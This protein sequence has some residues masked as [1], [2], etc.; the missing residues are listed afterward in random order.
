MSHPLAKKPPSPS[1]PQTFNGEI[2][3]AVGRYARSAVLFAFEDIGGPAALSFWAERNKDDF[4]TKL[5][6]KIIARESEVT[7]HKTVD[8]LMD[9]ID[10]EFEVEGEFDESEE[11][12]KMV[13][14][15]P[16]EVPLRN[17]NDPWLEQ[18]DPWNC[19]G[20]DFEDDE[21]LALA[22]ADMVDFEE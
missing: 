5:F 13:P 9:V 19:S 11:V 15:N 22:G 14:V 16:D 4:Y 20:A 7:H 6:P 17:G 8:Q 18:A 21:I 10:G 12:V 2:Y 1:V 3:Q